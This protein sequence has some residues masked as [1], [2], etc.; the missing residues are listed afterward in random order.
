MGLERHFGLPRLTRRHLARSRCPGAHPR[1]L[2][3]GVPARAAG[4]LRSPSVASRTNPGQT[5]EALCKQKW[6]GRRF[7]LPPKPAGSGAAVRA[8]LSKREKSC[9]Q[10]RRWLWGDFPGPANARAMPVPAQPRAPAAFGGTNTQV[11][12]LFGSPRV[13]AT[14]EEPRVSP[15]ELPKSEPPARGGCWRQSARLRWQNQERPVPSSA[16]R[17]SHGSAPTSRGSADLVLSAVYSPRLQELCHQRPAHLA[18]KDT[19]NRAGR[20]K[21]SERT[22]DELHDEAGG[23]RGGQRRCL[24]KLRDRF[25]QVS[26][27]VLLKNISQNAFSSFCPSCLHAEE[28]VIGQARALPSA[29]MLSSAVHLLPPTHGLLHA[30]PRL[31]HGQNHSA[32]NNLASFPAEK[33]PCHA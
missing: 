9:L 23:G 4:M 31:P 1:V 30:A 17:V 10:P 14:C 3:P 20:A 24:L 5:N 21:L 8:L 7:L 15:E 32:T 13:L 11:P 33:Q 29:P 18:L 12:C 16:S 2:A 19:R 27:S 26:F 28:S 6:F 22:D 25:L